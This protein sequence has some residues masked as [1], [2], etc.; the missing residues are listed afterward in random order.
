MSISSRSCCGKPMERIELVDAADVEDRFKLTYQILGGMNNNCI[1]V[2]WRSIDSTCK[3]RWFGLKTFTG[4]QHKYVTPKKWPPVV[5][6]LADEDAF[7][8]CDKN[9]CVQCTFRC[10][11]EF[12][13]YAYVENIGMVVKHLDEWVAPGSAS[14]DDFDSPTEIMEKARKAK[15]EKGE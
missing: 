11:R 4:M 5:F 7:A 10:K 6:A 8:Y 13:I 14:T 1:N 9:P 2:N 15:A 12:E 3:P